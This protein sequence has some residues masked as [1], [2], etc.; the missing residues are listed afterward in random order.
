MKKDNNKRQEKLRKQ[1][2][3]RFNNVDIAQ[4]NK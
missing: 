1:T 3:G 2:N 4:E